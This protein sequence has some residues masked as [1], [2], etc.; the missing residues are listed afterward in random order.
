M[1]ILVGAIAVLIASIGIYS[2]MTM[3]VTERAP[4]IGIMKEGYWRQS[5]SN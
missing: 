5:K 3:A 1:L 4:D 2:T